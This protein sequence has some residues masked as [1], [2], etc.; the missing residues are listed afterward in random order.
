M[1]ADQGED[2]RHGEEQRLGGRGD[3]DV[4]GPV[5]T[6]LGDNSPTEDGPEAERCQ[7]HEGS[8]DREPLG[9]T[10]AKPRN[11]TFPVMLATNT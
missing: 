7:C 4:T 11:T 6:E 1:R 8:G 3:S 10:T 5:M 9:P 2:H